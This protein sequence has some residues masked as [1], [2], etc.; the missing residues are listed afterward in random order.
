MLVPIKEECRISRQE[1]WFRF[2][3][4]D[5]SRGSDS[6]RT[7]IGNNRGLEPFR[8]AKIL[9]MLALAAIGLMQLAGCSV[10][11]H[12][13]SSSST[14]SPSSPGA[15]PVTVTVSGASQVRLGA[16]VQLTATVSNSTNTAVNWKVNGVAGG[17]STGGTISAAGLYTPPAAVPTSNTVTITAV[18]QASSSASGSLSEAILNPVPVV[19]SAF[20]SGASPSYTFTVNGTG[21][22]NGSQVQVQGTTL[23][24]TFVSSTQLTAAG[25]VSMPAGTTNVSVAVENPNPGSET[26]STVKAPVV[27][28]AVTG[29]TQVR[30]GATVQFAAAVANTSNTAVNWQV[31]GK[32]GGSS[33]TGT[34]SST[35]LYTPPTSVP[36]PDTVTITAVSQAVSAASGSLSEAILNPVPVV[37]SATA[38]GVPPS[39]TFTVNGTG[40]VGSS[41][42]LVQGTA[43][44]TTFVSSTQLAATT[45]L[46][47]GTTTASVE[48]TNP[49]PGSATSAPVNAS[50]Q[51]L[52]ST[53]TSASR[54]LDQATF[55][56]T[57]SDIQNVESIGMLAYLNQQ[58]QMTPTTLASIA[59]TPPT[60]CATNL[61]VCMQSE[62]WQAALTAPD[63]LRQRVAFALSEMYV[64]SIDSVNARAIMTFHN[65]LVNDAFGNF[66]TIMNDVTLSPGMGQYLNMLNSNKP[67]TGQIAN[68]NYARESMQ[69]FSIGIDAMNQDGSLQ[70]DGNGNPIP[71]YT[72][73]NVQAF[74]R[75]FT[76]WTYATS[77]GGSP[78]KF[79]NQTV[80]YTMPMVAV[81][82]GHD[83]TEKVL[84][85]GTV[86][87]A[88]QTAEED[89]A[90]ALQNVFNHPNVGPFV[91]RQLIQHLVSSNPS[92]AYVSRVAAVFADNGSGVRGDM[93]AVITAILLDTEARAGDTD[94]T[95]EGGHLREPVLWM[96][97][98]IRGLSFT[99]NDL[100][101]GNDVVANA[102]YSTLPNYTTNLGEVPYSANSVFN[103]FPPD[104]I[105]PGTST[106]APEFSLENTAS[107]N[108]RLSL[109]NTIVFNKITGF[110]VD[111][112]AT[113][114]LGTL[115]G[116]PGNLVDT[117]SMIFMHGQMSS[118]MRTAIVNN[119][120]GLTDLGERTR[121][122]VYLVITSSQYKIEH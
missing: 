114:P 15:T 31:N 34:I 48:V 70:L 35:G 42:I 80:N 104:Y 73:A 98:L 27:S 77:S 61:S 9:A 105:V 86:L 20:V 113:S 117:L 100:T 53:I 97:D 19:T 13:S 91:C 65:T 101:A 45:N 60:P 102:S 16:T 122:A 3:R 118:D 95:V 116:N 30:V 51:T 57:L 66:A 11:Y 109:A 25:N 119:I 99:N 2:V 37:T 41:Q 83:E 82:S 17:S 7:S 56:P 89:L 14:G 64:I 93:K 107:A 50:V 90:Q 87:P 69:L 18:S 79:P 63:Q 92:P 110:K 24:T 85:N 67:G 106:N 4:P 8:A 96:T 22:V 44:T 76:G 1:E 46:T 68:E 115:A 21:F 75:A 121:V 36:T 47:A 59:A 54:L 112:S 103:F 84:M 94:S 29:A 108:L 23:T 55:G 62:W 111:L 5:S 26:S 10:G 38:S 120:S 12:E 6:S 81:E 33:S 40:F 58:F 43:V 88:G 32:T 28:V 72:Q 39:Y 49:D 74:A 78:S 71:N 52:L